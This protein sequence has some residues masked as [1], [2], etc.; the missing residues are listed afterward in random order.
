VVPGSDGAGEALPV[1]PKVSRFRKG[2]KVVTLFNQGHLVGSLNQKTMA[3]AL[4]GMLNGTLRQ[5]GVFEENGL[6]EMPPSLSYLEAST[7]AC[8]G[9]TAWNAL[10]GL[11]PL[12]PGQVVVTQETGGVST[13]AVQFANAPGAT[14]IST[15]SSTAKAETLKKLGADHIINYKDEPNWGEKAKAL[16]GKGEEADHLIEVG[17]PRT[18]AQ[19]M[20]ACKIHGVISLIGFVAQDGTEPPSFAEAIGRCLTL[21]GFVVGSRAQFEDMVC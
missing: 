4:G 6:V 14:V 1:G 5:Y 2:D 10:Y 13:F 15:T 19:F 3:T 8:A 20:R 9:V 18:L 21:R 16:T 11:K 12:Q 17:G 7:L